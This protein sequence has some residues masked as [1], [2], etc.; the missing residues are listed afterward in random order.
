VASAAPPTQTYDVWNLTSS[1]ITV[2]GYDKSPSYLMVP[3]EN[4]PKTT[5]IPIGQNL[6]ITV[7]EGYGVIAKL[8]GSQHPQ[9]GGVQTWQVSTLLEKGTEFLPVPLVHMVCVPGD[10][11]NAGCGV[12]VGANVKAVADG[13]GTKITVPSDDKQKQ[14]EIRTS[15]CNHQ[16]RKQLQIDCHEVGSTTQV[17]AG[18]TVWSLVNFR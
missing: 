4:L 8:S 10:A 15:L 14:T 16:Y 17:T 5:V 11:K 9:Q 13:P 3:Q 1:A 18:N 6:Q 12:S 7:S 2:T